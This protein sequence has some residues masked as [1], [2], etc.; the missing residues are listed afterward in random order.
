MPED[1]QAFSFAQ[2]IRLLLTGG[3]GEQG[4]KNVHG[5]WDTMRSVCGDMTAVNYPHANSHT[6]ADQMTYDQVCMRV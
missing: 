3:R 6:E 4:L 1:L 5:I 2:S